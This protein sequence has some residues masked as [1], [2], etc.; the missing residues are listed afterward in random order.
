M[1]ETKLVSPLLDGFTLGAPI[2][3]HS[4]IC[5]CPAMKENSDK[6]YIVKV[7]AVPASQVQLDALLVTGAYKDP[8]AALDYFRQQADRISEEA[9]LLRQL[10]RLDGFLPYEGCQVTPMRKNRLGYHIYLLSSYK[11][12]LEKFIRRHPITHLE[13]V[14][15]GLDI[16]SALSMCRQA[17]YI[18][19]DLKPTNVFVGEDK[20]FRISDLG[21]AALD[22][23]RFTSLPEKYISPYSA[24]EVRDAMCT[25][26]DTVDTYALGMILYRIFNNGKLPE[27]P[28]D[29]MQ[30]LPA[31]AHGDE[32]ITQIILKACAPK[33]EDRWH[34]PADMGRAL[35]AY[36]QKN[37]INDVPVDNDPAEAPSPAETAA[38]QE[39]VRFDPSVF[40]GAADAASEV[41]T[42]QTIL[43]PV[44]ETQ[45]AVKEPEA[46]ELPAEPET[47]AAPPPE[48]TPEPEVPQEEAV[49]ETSDAPQEESLPTDAEIAEIISSLD[50]PDEPQPRVV[51]Q[52]ETDPEP[53]SFDLETEI[54]QVNSLL[55]DS[56]VSVRKSSVKLAEPTPVVMGKKRG[57]V[58][59]FL[60]TL[61]V[62]ILLAAVGFCGYCFYQFIYLQSV[63]RISIEGSH[64][65]MT[66][67]L[68]TDIKDELLTV[69]CVDIYGNTIQQK[70]ENHQAVFTDLLPD[71]LYKVSVQI[72]G[73]H[74]LVGQV[75]D[76]YTTEAQTEVVNL[77]AVTGQEDGSALLTMTV[78]GHEPDQWTATCTCEGEPTI[79]ETFSGHST[80]LRGMTVGKDYTIT[81]TADEDMELQ[82][83]N[84]ILFHASG[85]ISANNLSVVSRVNGDLTVSW[86]P[87]Q[88][89]PV[90]S[91]IAR[92]YGEGYDESQTLTETT[93]VFTNTLDSVEYTVE[94]TAEGMTQPSR[95]T[96]TANPV[97]IGELT[98]DDKTPEELRVSWTFEGETPENGWLLM[99][100]MDDSEFN[101]VVKCSSPSALISPRVPGATYRFTVQTAD[102]TTV[103]NGVHSYLCPAGANY[104]GHS[105]S[106]EKISARL[107]ETPSREWDAGSISSSDYKDRFASVQKI[108]MVLEAGVSFYLDH[109]DLNVLFVIRDA[110]GKVLPNLVEQVRYDWH[111]LWVGGDYHYAELNIPNT[112]PLTGSYRIDLYF[113]GCAV[114]SANFIIA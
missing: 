24:P 50:A 10:S 53:D 110:N 100:T 48:A 72:S 28:R 69:S 7:I 107:L 90:E 9:G 12:S 71:S 47:E 86:E 96:V 58:K 67:A 111:D 105:I 66:V 34:D 27:M 80:T 112:P 113:N 51:S 56:K 54:S 74:K 95:L 68:E 20:V 97:T 45:E 46:P 8:A 62:L 64:S 14:N 49:P 35:V 32:E 93:A 31:P 52:P 73:L 39:T 70:V 85:V 103:F 77:S 19:A 61:L 109:E 36:M 37:T 57:G 44:A 102:G 81:L 89:H 114:T 11:F 82:G 4:G 104:V 33:P 17:G 5:C 63:A 101:N 108:S 29:T 76:V 98:V 88:G 23:L 16:C 75:S 15:M 30:A 79:T 2:S 1:A 38:A 41:T 21:F 18:Y 6:K 78:H 40:A 87:P 92:C 60:I 25:L 83:Q 91:W 94:V 59:S 42:D 84:S 65:R 99:Y 3:N 26:N 22:S 13:A 55:N 106:A 43:L